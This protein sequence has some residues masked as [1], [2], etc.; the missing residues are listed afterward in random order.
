MIKLNEA[1]PIEAGV[2]WPTHSVHLL[3]A[4]VEADLVARGVASWFPFAE[5]RPQH[6]LEERDVLFGDSMT[7]QYWVD[8][9]PTASY[10]PSTGVLTLTLSS[11]GLATGWYVDVF[12][13]SYATLKKHRRYAVT[14]VDSSTFTVN[15]GRNVTGLP[16]GAL[17]GTTFARVPT[18]RGSNSWVNWLQIAGGWPLNIV[19]NGAQSGDTT[20][21]CLARLYE[22]CLAYEPTRV[23]MQMPGINDMSAGNGPIAEDVIAANQRAICD[24][25]LGTGARLFVLTMTPVASGESR[26]NLQSMASVVRLNR[27][28]AQFARGRKN[29]T[30]LDAYRLVVDPTDA[31]GYA[32]STMVKTTGGSPDRIH[33]SIRGGKAVGDMVW[34]SVRN[35]IPGPA[36]TLPV[37]T[38]DSFLDTS[39]TLTSPTRASNVISATATA[40][41]FHTG[42]LVKVQGGTSEVLNL[43]TRLTRL[44]ANTISFPSSGADG[45]ITGTVRVSRCSNLFDNPLLLTATGGTTSGGASGTVAD[46]IKAVLNGAM[47][48]VVASVVSEANGWGNAQQLVCTPSGADGYGAFESEVTSTYNNYIAERRRYRFEASLKMTGVADVPLSEIMVRL[49]VNA[50]GV[51]YSSHAINTFDSDS[52]NA[53]W[54]GHVRTPDLVIPPGTITQFYFQVYA[55]F[56]ATSANALTMQL[57]RVAVHELDI[58]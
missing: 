43:N 41:S 20:G 24:A 48:S 55:K 18:R 30:V 35:L 8:T 29:M 49:M 40:H 1:F 42:D 45:A 4:A 34:S 44:D 14:Y 50:G 52:L 57:S 28:L 33:Y 53:D 58:A 22:H 16:T 7:S 10:E 19:Y 21:D 25:I 38:A 3:D 47:T 23:W 2:V 5:M 27:R 36:D 39:V 11:H 46:G 26:G 17:T 12:N 56:S 32:L 31:T 9:T 37:S 51:L 15:I 13:R 54:S 6:P